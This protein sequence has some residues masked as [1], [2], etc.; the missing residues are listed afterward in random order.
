MPLVILTKASAA[1]LQKQWR[2]NRCKETSK[3]IFPLGDVI[4]VSSVSLAAGAALWTDWQSCRAGR[5]ET[6]DVLVK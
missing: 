6:A 4:K 5:G 1:V 2:L 3:K